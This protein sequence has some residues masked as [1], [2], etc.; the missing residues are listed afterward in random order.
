MDHFRV[1]LGVL[2]L[3][4]MLWATQKEPLLP[5]RISV[6]IWRK[7]LAWMNG[8]VAKHNVKEAGLIFSKLRD[9]DAFNFVALVR[10]PI[11]LAGS[12][13]LAHECRRL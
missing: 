13:C 9:S 1:K 2:Y 12:P 5:L 6:E 11:D 3:L 8:D 10:R 7:L 4:Y